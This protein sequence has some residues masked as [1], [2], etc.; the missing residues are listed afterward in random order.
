MQ[1]THKN[2]ASLLN[3]YKYDIK[4]GDIIA[5]TIFSKEKQGYLVDIGAEKAAYLPE[6]EILF[7]C[8]K[9]YYIE[10]QLTQEFFILAKSIKTNIILSIKRLLYIRSWERIKQLKQEDLIISAQV[11]GINKGGILIE[12]EN[13]QGFIPKSHLCYVININNIINEQIVCKFLI[14]N[15]PSNQLILSNRSAILEQNISII[16]LGAIFDTKITEIQ[17][18]G[19]FVNIYNIPAL[20][21][22]SEMNMQNIH[23]F[24]NNFQIGQNIAVKII[25]IDIK[26]GRLSVSRKYI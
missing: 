5:G 17:P 4:K 11:K 14:A 8:Q 23:D 3:K 26:Q 25:H 7:S 20:L 9:K 19:A 15:Q 24:M 1:F 22:V 21:H 13:I 2:F 12:I 10:I 18:Y 6:E 16:K